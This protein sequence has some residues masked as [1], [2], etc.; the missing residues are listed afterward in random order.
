MV[1]PE[2]FPDPSDPKVHIFINWV[3]LLGIS[4][5]ISKQLNKKIEDYTNTA[6]FSRELT[7][8]VQS[9]PTSLSLSIRTARTTSFDRDVHRLH[10]TYL[11]NVTLLHLSKS[12]QLLLPKASKAAIVAA[13]C[14]AR[15]FEDFLTRGNVRFLSGEA[16]WEIAVALLAL[17]H[18]RRIED[19]RAHADAD[20]R[21]LRT[22]LRQM[23]LMW[24]SS[25]MFAAAIDKLSA[26]DDQPAAAPAPS[27]SAG[28]HTQQQNNS[29]NINTND[30]AVETG[31]DG[32]RHGVE[33]AEM[34]GV[35]D[36]DDDD[37]DDENADWMDAFPFVTEETSP[38]IGA[39]LARN[40]AVPLP[41]LD[42]PLDISVNLQEFLALPSDY[43]FGMLSL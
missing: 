29:S 25:R 10:V 43:S 21:T 34:L 28:R 40:L 37:D 42:W 35:I 23:A 39:V 7:S 31:S 1:T 32:A 14:V 36:D 41:E 24:P 27:A 5:R 17:L 9:L 19:L 30:N 2:D 22:A 3:E 18:A 6:S 12:S 15:L 26:V 8:W 16:G 38:L 13:S 33:D 20:I 4:G 11:T